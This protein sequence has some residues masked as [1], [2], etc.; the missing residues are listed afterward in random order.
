MDRLSLSDRVRSSV[1]WEGLRVEPRLLHIERSHL[2]LF[3]FLLL[4][5]PHRV[6]CA[7]RRGA[8]PPCNAESQP[9]VITDEAG[10]EPLP[11][12]TWTVLQIEGK[13]AAP[14]LPWEVVV[15][16]PQR[17]GGDGVLWFHHAL[18]QHRHGDCSTGAAESFHCCVMLSFVE[19]HSIYLREA[20][21]FVK[22]KANK[23][24]F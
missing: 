9:L 22:Q 20:D 16:G 23:T 11:R 10:G 15:L 4:F 24:I 13:A 1:V 3:F 21:C 18:P 19:V 14:P 6:P 5:F 12:P 17:R 8:F 7:V 2:R